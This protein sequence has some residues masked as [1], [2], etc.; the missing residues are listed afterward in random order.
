MAAIATDYAETFS[1][2]TLD[3]YE[4]YEYVEN[5]EEED[6]FG[7]ADDFEVECVIV[8]KMNDYMLSEWG[9]EDRDKYVGDARREVVDHFR[10]K[11]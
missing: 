6:V 11:K 4:M 10:D 3:A 2:S 1:A 5:T 9:Y 7:D 8:D